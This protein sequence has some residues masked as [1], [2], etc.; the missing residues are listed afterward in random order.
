M[1][2][3]TKYLAFADHRSRPFFD[4]LARVRADAPR[5]VA[6]LGCGPGNLT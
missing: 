6:D 4:L 3:P 1:W 5:R 2:D